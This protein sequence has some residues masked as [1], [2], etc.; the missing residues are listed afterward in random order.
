VENNPQVE[1]G[2]LRA[3]CTAANPEAVG[4]RCESCSRPV[5]RTIF[6]IV[7]TLSDKLLPVTASEHIFASINMTTSI[8][9]QVLH[10]NLGINP[11]RIVGANGHYLKTAGGVNIFDASGGAAVACIGHNNPR[12]KNAIKEQL[13]SVAYCFSPWFTT[14]A[15]EKLATFLTESTS[16]HM[17]K[18]FVC[19]SGT[20]ISSIAYGCF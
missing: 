19:G 10:A 13:D 15:Y 8:S 2:E 5:F 6:F 18:V 12:V 3:F 11:P 9:T 20:S 17:E 14:S 16:G 7:G 1:F 4:D